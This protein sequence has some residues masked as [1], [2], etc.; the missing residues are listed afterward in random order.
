M[1]PSLFLYGRLNWQLDLREQA[2]RDWNINQYMTFCWY[3]TI[4][5]AKSEEEKVHYKHFMKT[6]NTEMGLVPFMGWYRSRHKEQTGFQSVG[7]ILSLGQQLPLLTEP[8]KARVC[9]PSAEKKNCVSSQYFPVQFNTGEHGY[10][11]QEMDMKAF[12]RAVGPAFRKNLE[13]GPFETVNIYPLMCHILQIEPEP[14]DGSL[15]L[16]KDMLAEGEW[17]SSVA[18]DASRCACLNSSF[19]IYRLSSPV[20]QTARFLLNK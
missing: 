8:E 16:T 17:G 19:I 14:N 10:D 11:N 5:G 9:E 12:F 18:S 3:Q 15:D 4:C 1:A 20:C 2:C 6:D 13:V 7:T